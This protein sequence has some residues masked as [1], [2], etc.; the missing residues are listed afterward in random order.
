MVGGD[1]TSVVH[2]QAELHELVP[3]RHERNR[4]RGVDAAAVAQDSMPVQ[5]PGMR[6]W[7]EE[8]STHEPIMCG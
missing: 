6:L 7:R 2:A 5:A 8:H 4:R 3:A 1:T